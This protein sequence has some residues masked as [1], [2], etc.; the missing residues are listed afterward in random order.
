MSKY[1]VGDIL[2]HCDD[3]RI[4]TKHTI[5]KEYW[6]FYIEEPA[7]ELEKL[8]GGNHEYSLTEDDL[9]EYKSS[10]DEAFLYKRGQLQKSISEKIDLIK[11]YQSEI[12]DFQEKLKNF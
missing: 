8:D 2:F 5:T 1:K 6:D 11:V 4:V 7:F 9:E 12:N 10:P 3:N